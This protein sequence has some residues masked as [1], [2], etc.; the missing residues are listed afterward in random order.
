MVQ[1][2]ERLGAHNVEALAKALACQLAAKLAESL[3]FGYTRGID[4]AELSLSDNMLQLVIRHL[5]KSA[6]THLAAWPL[7]LQQV[8]LPLRKVHICDTA[9]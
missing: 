7:P 5:P 8:R 3:K 2:S 1:V 4:G 6:V 9:R